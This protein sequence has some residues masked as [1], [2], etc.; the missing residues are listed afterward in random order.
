M[1]MIV[2]LYLQ[3]SEEEILGLELTDD[4]CYNEVVPVP[5]EISVM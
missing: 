2:F 1:T 5:I 3:E 4:D